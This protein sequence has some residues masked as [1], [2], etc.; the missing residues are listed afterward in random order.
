MKRKKKVYESNPC[1][2]PELFLLNVVE[3]IRLFW[4]N[5][6]D[7]K[8]RGFHDTAGSTC[9]KNRRK[10]GLTWVSGANTRS[11]FLLSYEGSFV[12]MNTFFR[13]FHVRTF[14]MM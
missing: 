2:R 14:K 4:A 12:F 1:I 10:G 13:D 7:E 5:P 3:V 9:T 8:D 11:L 6:T